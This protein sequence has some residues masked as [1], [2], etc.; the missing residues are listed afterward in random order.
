M[1]KSGSLDVRLTLGDL[2]G[3]GS[4]ALT[5]YTGTLMTVFVVQALVAFTTILTCT[6]VLTSMFSHLPM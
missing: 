4:R 3:S 6:V 2:V 1:R 5:R